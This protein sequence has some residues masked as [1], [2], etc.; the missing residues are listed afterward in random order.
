MADL[1]TACFS[2]LLA[3]LAAKNSQN[4]GLCL[5]LVSSGHACQHRAYGQAVNR[6]L[7]HDQ[8]DGGGATASHL[9]CSPN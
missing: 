4:L 1:I 5:S 3:A 6:W 9:G 7:K 2:Q 8:T